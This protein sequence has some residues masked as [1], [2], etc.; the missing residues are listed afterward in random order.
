[1]RGSRDSKQLVSHLKQIYGKWY[2]SAES[3]T[4]AR[5]AKRVSEIQSNLLDSWDTEVVEC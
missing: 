1:M 5:E 3:E 2:V 4:E